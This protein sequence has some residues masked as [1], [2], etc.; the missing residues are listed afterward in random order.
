MKK[1]GGDGAG[2]MP[3][4]KS[5]KKCVDAVGDPD[6]NNNNSTSEDKEDDE[7][8]MFQYGIIPLK[9]VRDVDG[10]TQ[11]ILWQNKVPN[12]ARSLRP[13]Y[14]IREVET[15]VEL[16]DFVINETDVVRND[17]N[18]NGLSIRLDNEDLHVSCVMKDSMKDLKFKKAISG[19]GGADCILCKSKVSD[20]TD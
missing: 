17:L 12:S 13:I 20:W 10:D 19:L 18:M 14:L 6:N 1:D 8:H 7:D 2:T 4:L 15:D 9:L 11:E 16:L 3:A 5:K